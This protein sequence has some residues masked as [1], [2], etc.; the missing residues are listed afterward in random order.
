MK[1]FWFVLIIMCLP[2]VYA[3]LTFFDNPDDVFIIGN[4]SVVNETETN[5]TVQTSSGGGGGGGGSGGSTTGNLILIDSTE[6]Q[7]VEI[8][9]KLLDVSFILDENIIS[10]SENLISITKLKNFGRESFPVYLTY[11]IYN[12]SSNSIYSTK[13]VLQVRTEQ[14]EVSKFSDFKAPQGNYRLDLKVDYSNITE[15]FSQLFEINEEIIEEKKTEGNY[16]IILLIAAAFLTGVTIV[17]FI[18]LKKLPK[19]H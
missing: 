15:I 12:S 2:F 19:I 13:R 14:A 4:A 3:E 11:T 5:D 8:P 9:E 18:I 10:R 7:V 16:K 6:D 1:T 17:I